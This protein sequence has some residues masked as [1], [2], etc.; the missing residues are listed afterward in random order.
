MK[1]TFKSLKKITPNIDKAFKEFYDVLLN[2]IY[3]STFFE[4]EDQV[5]M[6]IEKQ[7]LFFTKAIDMP[8]S[9][10]SVG[11]VKLGEFHYDIR[12][13]YVDFMKGMDILEENFLLYSQEKVH[14]IELMQDIF[15]YFK[16]IKAQTAKGYLNRM[17]AE[18][19]QDIE[20]FFDHLSN[21]NDEFAK[22][23]VVERI[24]W[25]KALIHAIKHKEEFDTT[26]NDKKFMQ[27]IKEA[28]FVDSTQK[29]FIE[30]L[31]KRIIINTKNLFY[32][33]SKGDYLE[34]LPL[35]S[36]LLSIYKLTLLI[37]NSVSISMTEHI[38]SHLKMD[39]LT[40]LY[41]KDAFEQFLQKE[42]A[43]LKRNDMTFCVAYIDIDDFKEINDNYGHWSGDKVLEK[44]G[45]ILNENIRSS[46][47]GFRIGGDEFAIIF[48]EATREQTLK[49]CKK[50][51]SKIS[52]FEFKYNDKKSFYIS[53]S[54]GIY[55][56]NK[57]NKNDTL[58]DIVK[59][60]DEKLYKS[61]YSGKG[62][63]SF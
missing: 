39:K 22:E 31:E 29:S 58:E 38:I 60:V 56:C 11:Y 23:L 16:F 51:N 28:S 55:E 27:L 1:D 5:L 54:I 8:I 2:D 32:F 14:S 10:I 46:D 15:R 19:E 30:D 53:T 41:R 25:L 37:S 48:K 21:E 62:L 34:I 59:K 45:K 9:K 17:L 57:S 26:E 49:V 61:K 47:I 18:D 33:L 36:F 12:I 42:L 43:I 44:I 24:N 3:F 7:K 13:P 40:S 4:D 6:L 52:E 20:K 63:I 35:Y 50:I